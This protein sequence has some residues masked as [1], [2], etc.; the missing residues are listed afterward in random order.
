MNYFIKLQKELCKR[1]FGKELLLSG[2]K[3]IVAFDSLNEAVEVGENKF[4]DGNYSGRH[5][6]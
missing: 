6:A 4:G 3:I 2:K 5:I 1:F